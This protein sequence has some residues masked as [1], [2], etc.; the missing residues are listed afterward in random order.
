MPFFVRSYVLTG[1]V[2]YPQTF[3]DLFAPDWKVPVDDVRWMTYYIRE[4]AI[5]GGADLD[6]AGMGPGERLATWFDTW[7]RHG[8]LPW[9]AFWTVSVIGSLA[10]AS[11]WRPRE[12][13]RELARLWIPCSVTER[14]S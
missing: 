11:W 2:V 9:L 4:F 6:L 1:Y 10:M 14:S 3:V 7:L 8:S 5:G 12:L 13:W